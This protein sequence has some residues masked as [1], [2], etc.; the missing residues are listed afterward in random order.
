MKNFFLSINFHIFVKNT[1]KSTCLYDFFVVYTV[2]FI[3][4][5]FNVFFISIAM[6]IG[7]TPPGTGVMAPAT[8]FAV[9]HSTSPTQVFGAILFMPTSITTAPSFII[10]LVIKFGI[11]TAATR[12]SADFV[13]SFKSLV[14]E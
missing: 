11:P 3:S 4:A 12:I 9:S 8:S 10:S 7:P 13:F 14:R 1:K 2:L 6:V 5:A